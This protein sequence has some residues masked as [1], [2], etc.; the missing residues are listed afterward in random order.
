MGVSAPWRRPVRVPT[1]APD[2]EVLA[3]ARGVSVERGTR[4]VLD[5]ADLD[6]RAGE[7]VALVGPNG[8]GKTTLLHALARDTR[9]ATGSVEIM[10]APAHSWTAAELAMRR[11]VLPQDVVVSFPFLVRDVVRMGR[12]V[13]ARTAEHDR[14]DDAVREALRE[15]DAIHLAG[16]TF[17]TLSG[18]ERA[19]V[20]LA[21]VWAQ[22]AQLVL[23]DEP[24]AALDV[25][26]QELVLDGARRHAARGDGVVVVLHD[27]ASA[28]RHAD[29]VV[30][31][32]GGRVVAD[33][34]PA[35]VLTAERLSHVYGH[36][37][38]VFAHPRTGALLVVPR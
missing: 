7:V 33:G 1:R 22:A 20:A 31:L 19:R 28:A 3:S 5:S 17:P 6:V 10:G 8:A 13:W 9:I 4:R 30:L 38:D 26:H 16:R 2:G 14:D 11:A 27:L 24:T 18:G 32:A 37:L 12:S 36:G 15:A 34:G 23:L 25:H 29:R 21:R 35:D